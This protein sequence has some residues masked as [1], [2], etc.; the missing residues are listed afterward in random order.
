MYNIYFYKD[1]QGKEPL[2]DYLRDLASTDSKDSRI[3]LNKINDYIKIRQTEGTRTG[4]PFVKHIEGGFENYT[5]LRIE[6]SLFSGL[7]TASYYYIIL[8]KNLRGHRFLKLK[9][10]GGN[11]KTY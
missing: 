2:L 11:S 10:S 6:F 8:G 4:E 1:R 7:I 5:L 9:R 3:K